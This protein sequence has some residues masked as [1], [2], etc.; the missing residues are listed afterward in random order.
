MS[1][2]LKLIPPTD[3]R[4]LSM[5]APFID[6]NLKEHD[7]KD[8]NELTE[9]MFMAMKKYSGLGLSANQVGL[10]YRMFVAGGH[11]QIENGLSIA[12]YNPTIKSMSEEVTMLKEGC[13]SF[14]FLFLDVK[15]PRKVTFEYE[16]SAGE[17]KEANL[18]G[19]MARVCLHE[20]DHMQGI[21]FTE[22]VTKFRLQRAKEKA[23]KM[24]KAAQREQKS[25]KA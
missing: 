5:V 24:I 13:L 7:F 2:E 17:K 14:P 11:P 25:N 15:R 6:E 19:M 4:V 3:P 12:M 1:I 21:V 10:P 8:R 9:A 20:Y 16:D 22:K 23:V 18:D